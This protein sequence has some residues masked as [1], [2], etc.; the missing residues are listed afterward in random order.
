MTNAP[1]K[2]AQEAIMLLAHDNPN[3]SPMELALLCYL[4]G[5]KDGVNETNAIYIREIAIQ[6]AMTL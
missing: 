4:E 3:A 1:L 2:E 6:K 5:Y